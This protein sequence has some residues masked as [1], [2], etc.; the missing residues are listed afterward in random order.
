MKP[1]KSRALHVACVT[2]F[3]LMVGLRPASAEDGKPV[4][5]YVYK[6]V[7]QREL[8][9]D[10]LYPDDW[11]ASDKRPAIVFFSGGAWRS[12]GTRQFLQQG[13]YFAKRGMVTVRAEYRDSTKDKVKPDTCLK[14]AVSAMR[15][16]RK[17]AEELG[18]DPER[19]VASG[20]S[21][22]GYLAA[23]VATIEDFHSEGDDLSVSPK[24]NAMVLF[25]PVLDF[26]TLDRAAEFGIA[27]ELAVKISPLGHVTKGLPPTL[28]LIGSEDRFL[29]QNRQFVSKATRLG[30]R[31]E[32]DL[33]EGQP[34]AYFN[35]S[36]WMEKTVASADRFLVSLGYLGEEPRVAL[37]SSTSETKSSSLQL[38]L[39]SRAET[40]TGSGQFEEA[41]RTVRW[42]PKATAIIVCDMWDDH[43]CKGAAGRVAQMAPAVDLAVKAAR[44]QGVFIIH[45]PS[46]TMSFYEDTP[47]RRRALEAPFTKAPV[48]IKWNR[49]DPQREGEPLAG[50][51]D[52]GCACPEPCPN[53]DVDENGIRHWRKGG[54]VPWTRQIE[55][56]EIARE[57]AI[58]DNGQEIY[59]LLEQR[60]IDNVILMG[61]HT[62]ICVSGRPFGLRQMVYLGKNVVL[63]RDLTDALFQ[64][65]SGD[66]DQFRGTDLV[67]EHIEKHICP[68]ITSKSITGK[69]E[70]RFSNPADDHQR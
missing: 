11:S 42:D 23:A 3:V 33:A 64:P 30:V 31:V 4:P 5:Q 34:H 32:L 17:N 19:I 22:G 36:P 28:I 43:T 62:N 44:Q 14:D 65:T 10:V 37:P 26:V 63:C 21:A 27:G 13:Q 53:F 7:G 57:D 68:T 60:G 39:R 24:P 69:P 20:G 2:M 45:A 38:E 52:G 16:V 48:E 29:D 50:I 47:Q 1:S 40:H 18:I 70:F 55:T 25:N 51:V 66:I 6:T 58:S 49:W 61:V 9:A 8:K 12:G 41:V 59:N 67:V 35:R 15:W 56:I 46:G 54:Q